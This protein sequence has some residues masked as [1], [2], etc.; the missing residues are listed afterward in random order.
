[1]KDIGIDTT[2]AE[3]S[4]TSKKKEEVTTEGIEASEF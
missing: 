3:V 2:N 1:M 4:C